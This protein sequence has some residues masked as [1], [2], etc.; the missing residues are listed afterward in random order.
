[1]R[2]PYLLDTNVVSHMLKRAVERSAQKPR[3]RVGVSVI[4]E[5]ER[6]RSVVVADHLPGDARLLEQQH[7]RVP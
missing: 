6:D 3:S 5:M 7:V 1:M 4:T 2:D